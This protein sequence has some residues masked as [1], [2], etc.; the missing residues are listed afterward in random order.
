MRKLLI[1]YD[2]LYGTSDNATANNATSPDLLYEGSIGIYGILKS[3]GVPELLTPSSTASNYLDIQIFQGGASEMIPTAK[4]KLAD[5]KSITSQIYVAP[6]KQVSYVG[7]DGASGLLNLPTIAK[8][9]FGTLKMSMIMESMN[10]I[11][12]E[13]A[14][15]DTAGLAASAS[16]YA[17]LKNIANQINNTATSNKHIIAGI[18]NNGT[19]LTDFTG[20]G[21]AVLYTKGS[22][23]ARHMI[24]NTTSGWVASTATNTLAVGNT[25]LVPHQATKSMTIAIP[26]SVGASDKLVITVNGT[27]YNITLAAAANATAN[28]IVVAAALNAGS[29]GFATVS[30]G[31]LTFTII[32]NSVLSAFVNTQFYDSTNWATVPVSTQTVT[33]GDTLGTVYQV[34]AVTVSGDATFELDRSFTGE[35][36][37]VLGGTTVTYTTTAVMNTGVLTAGTQYGLQVISLYYYEQFRLA[38]SADTTDVLS[39]ATVTTIV[40]TSLGNGTYRD[41]A[42]QESIGGYYKGKLDTSTLPSATPK[43]N[44]AKTAKVYRTYSIE[45]NSSYNDP[46]RVNALSTNA[47]NLCVA[48]EYVVAKTTNYNQSNFETILELFETA[49]TLPAFDSII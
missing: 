13:W 31:T 8:N 16:G 32:G 49:G 1:G 24:Q 37:Y 3:T 15:Y 45:V 28:A 5:V 47:Y 10:P 29:Q 2:V 36:C 34:A 40:N 26:A 18:T 25:V 48:F 27:I 21:T 6:D 9:N 19:V 22:T 11:A 35:S 38:L 4:M 33:T 43:T 12:P 20:N 42:N 23:T 44:Y 39:D 7:Y 30:T 14:V 46:T 41:V 17:V